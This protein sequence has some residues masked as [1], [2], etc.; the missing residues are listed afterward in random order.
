[1]I[2]S[3][4]GK[5]VTKTAVSLPCSFCPAQLCQLTGSSWSQAD[6]KSS[7]SKMNICP[8]KWKQEGKLA[9]ACLLLRN[10]SLPSL[11]LGKGHLGSWKTKLHYDD[12]HHCYDLTLTWNYSNSYFQAELWCRTIQQFH[13]RAHDTDIH[14]QHDFA[15]GSVGS[16]RLR[17]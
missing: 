10:E 5:K 9:S 1:M 12:L 13:R 15:F 16:S 8:V 7:G 11:S 3:E 6:C 2:T 4:I 14:H 17:G